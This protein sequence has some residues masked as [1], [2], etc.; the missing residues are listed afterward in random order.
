MPMR[1]PVIARRAAQI[2]FGLVLVLGACLL[3]S[4]A[5]EVG[6][7]AG[8]PSPSPWQLFAMTW[9]G[10]FAVYAAVRW[11]VPG[12]HR[13]ARRDQLL[14]ASLAVPA[15]GLALVLPLT[16]HLPFAAALSGLD[17]FDDW[18]HLAVFVTGPAH[19]IFAILTAVRAVQLARGRAAVSVQMIFILTVLVSAIPF[20]V[21]FL[22]PPLLVALTGLPI[23]P[24]LQSMDRIAAAE[25]AARPEVPHATARRVV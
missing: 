4:S 9:I 12:L 16:V 1:D 5:L 25:R 11:A 8:Q 17:G 18:A 3:A 13:L 22:L 7:R 20:A 2:G 14:A 23:V 6:F 10:A 24:L 15:F 19:V 21:L